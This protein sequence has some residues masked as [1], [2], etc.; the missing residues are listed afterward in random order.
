MYYHPLIWPASLWAVT[1]PGATWTLAL[2]F[3]HLTPLPAAIFE[4][5][6]VPAVTAT[7]ST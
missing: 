3:R 2:F 1:F 5:P 4:R 7:T 6:S